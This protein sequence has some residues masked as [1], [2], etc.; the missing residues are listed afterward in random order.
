M[1]N[2]IIKKLWLFAWALWPLAALAQPGPDERDARLAT[3]RAEVFSRVLRLSPEEAQNFWPLYNEFTDRREQLQR[4]LRPGKQPDLMTD[5]GVK[6]QIKRHFDLKQREL[7]LERELYQK[8]KKVLPLRKI[9]K[10]PMAEREFRESLV[11][12]LQEVR[13]R[14]QERLQGRPGNRGR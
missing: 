6:E 4:E 9:A 2:D 11:K 12:R 7:D 3:F 13:E 8:L 1:K 10:L 5:A 14:R